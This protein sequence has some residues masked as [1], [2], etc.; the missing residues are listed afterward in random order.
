MWQNSHSQHLDSREIGIP[1]PPYDPNVVI[2]SSN[3]ERWMNEQFTKS[4]EKRTI[5]MKTDVLG[6][7]KSSTGKI[8]TKEIAEPKQKILVHISDMHIRETDIGSA[9][10][11]MECNSE[12]KKCDYSLNGKKVSEKEHNEFMEKRN[13]KFDR[14]DRG[15]RNLPIPGVIA[16]DDRKWTAWMSA[17]EISELTKNYKELAIT[18]YRE[19]IPM[20]PQATI[21]SKVGL[22]T[23]A[24]PLGYK[25]NGIGVY[26]SEPSCI[27]INIWDLPNKNNYTLGNSRTYPCNDDI[28]GLHHAMSA[29]VIQISS[30]LAHVFGFG[31]PYMY[32]I[33]DPDNYSLP[34]LIG[35][36]S[37]GYQLPNNEYNKYH[38]NYDGDMDN[39]IYNRRIINFVAA[40][41]V[42]SIPG[43]ATYYVSS[44]GKALNAITVGAVDPITNE[45]KNYSKWKN[46]DIGNRKP[47]LA[48]YTDI[49]LD[50]L[51]VTYD[52]TS[53]ATPLAAGFTASLL[54]Q[55]PIYKKKPALVKAVLLTGETMPISNANSWDQDNAAYYS[56]PIARGV[57][58]YK[59]VQGG[60]TKSKWWEGENREFFDSNNEIR[61]TENNIQAN[62]RYRIAISWLVP[63][64]YIASNKQ[65]PQK[66]ALYVF[67][68]GEMIGISASGNSSFEIVDFV[69]KSSAPLT[70]VLERYHNSGHGEVLLGYHMQ[71][72]F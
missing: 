2:I 7:V 19:P 40:G 38:S 16:T 24:F 3:V 11:S 5:E 58:N 59:G 51:S 20:V 67:Q 9:Y 23:Y 27:G 71:D 64:D 36:H 32:P 41:N 65:M 30:P 4:S 12:T 49:Y 57:M 47:E 52:G 54:E 60:G 28:K 29:S 44:P 45:Y 48:M 10:G 50:N 62:K 55:F 1:P 18:D 66:V 14:P 6:R 31:W 72:N 61:F 63:G 70:I 17:E 25:G 13:Q 15:K 21:L 53:A 8:E 69:T 34:I 46:P 22:S 33:F 42:G 68:N 35:S 43:D 26:V 39:H 56:K 37:Y